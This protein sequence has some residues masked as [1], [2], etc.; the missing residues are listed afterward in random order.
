MAKRLRCTPSLAVAEALHAV[1]RD[2]EVDALLDEFAASVDLEGRVTNLEE[3]VS[4]LEDDD[5]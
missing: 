5:A 3:R 2:E 1:R 4:G